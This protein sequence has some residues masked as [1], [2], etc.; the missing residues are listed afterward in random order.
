MDG[1]EAA[2]LVNE[3]HELERGRDPGHL[4]DEDLWRDHGDV[5]GD[6]QE[7]AFGKLARQG[8]RAKDLVRP[9]ARRVGDENVEGPGE[10][11]K[12]RVGLGPKPRLGLG[13]R[14]TGRGAERFGACEGLGEPRKSHGLEGG[15]M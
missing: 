1:V 14:L 11:A 6:S 10:S 3:H 7:R 15:G 12:Q 2:E 13:G 9:A 5:P 4:H 8:V